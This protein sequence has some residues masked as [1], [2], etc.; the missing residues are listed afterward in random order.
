MFE[1][2][3]LISDTLERIK[4][5]TTAYDHVDIEKI[6]NYGCW[7]QK[8]GGGDSIGGNA[9][10]E[11]DEIC[12]QWYKKRHCLKLEGGSCRGA[13]VLKNYYAE[14]DNGELYDDE[15]DEQGF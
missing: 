4:N 15:N 1:F 8:I 13:K 12:K 3:T 9:V 11:F 2:T 6:N 10:D 7:C 5:Y 14:P